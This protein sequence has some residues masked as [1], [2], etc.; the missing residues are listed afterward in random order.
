M[1]RYARTLC[2]SSGSLLKHVEDTSHGDLER[3]TNESSFT[4]SCCIS[5]LI[6][7]VVTKANGSTEVDKRKL[8]SCNL[9][10]T[11]PTFL[12]RPDAPT[13]LLS[14]LHYSTKSEEIVD[15]I[16]TKVKYSPWYYSGSTLPPL[17]SHYNVNFVITEF[18]PKGDDYEAGYLTPDCA[19]RRRQRLSNTGK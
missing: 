5:W 10:G 4:L 14:R 7:M 13:T 9:C 11:V 1:R 6:A 8:T 18:W 3:N 2:S 16:R 12:L 19:T 17:E 15:C